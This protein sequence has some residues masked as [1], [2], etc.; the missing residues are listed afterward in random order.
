MFCEPEYSSSE[1]YHQ[2]WKDLAEG[3]VQSGEFKRK[4]K[5][6]SDVWIN[7]SY[8]PVK[9]EYGKVNKII[10]IAIDITIQKNIILQVQD[11]ISKVS[12]EGDLTVRVES[13]TSEGDYKILSESINE[14]IAVVSILFS[15]TQELANLVATSSE[16]MTA[17][18]EQMKKSTVEMSTAISEMASGVNEQEQQIDGVN[19]LVDDLLSAS[20]N[21]ANKSQDIHK[22]AG[23]GQERAADGVSTINKVVQNMKEIQ[24]SAGITSN[25]IQVLTQEIRR[26][27]SYA[28]CYY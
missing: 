16:E 4:R 12:E 25:S 23:E 13:G 9:D 28:S 7:A 1:V 18:G 22:V 17:K 8:T 11:V 6:G 5:D 3:K 24:E 27:C 20:K 19:Q 21:M 15:E 10:K 26:Y 2:F 14:L